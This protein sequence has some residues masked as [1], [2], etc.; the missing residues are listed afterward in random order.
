MTSECTYAA[1]FPS[2]RAFLGF[3]AFG[4]GLLEVV[5]RHSLAIWEGSS[6]VLGSILIDRNSQDR[7]EHCHQCKKE[8]EWMHFGIRESSGELV[9]EGDRGVE[10]RDGFEKKLLM[11]DS[12]GV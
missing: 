12:L 7:N 3:E 11:G 2:I 8:F 9:L 1:K 5:L 10:E 4:S 6:I